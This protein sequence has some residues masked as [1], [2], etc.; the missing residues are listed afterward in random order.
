LKIFYSQNQMKHSL[1]SPNPG[2]HAYD[3]SLESPGRVDSILA[4]LESTTWAEILP[5]LDFGLGPVLEIHTLGYMDYLRDAYKNWSPYSTEEHLAF[6][7]YKPGFDPAAPHPGTIPDQDGFFMTDMHVPVNAF[8]YQAALSSAQCALSA[9]H[10][11]TNNNATTFALCRP[12]GHHAGPDICG[13]YCFLN[14]AAIAANWL[15]KRGKVA[16]LDID[17]HA[18]NGTQAIFYSR[19]DVLTISLHADPVRQYPNYSGYAH[20]IGVG[21]GENFHR[22]FPLP[23]HISDDH[24]LKFLDQAIDLVRSYSPDFLVVSAGL[25]T[26][27]EDPLGDFNISKT[28]FSRIGDKLSSL[29]QPTTLVLEGGY[30]INKLGENLIAL[31]TPFVI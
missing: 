8:T 24:Y 4:A 17:F 26:Y 18:G 2:S 7:P 6:I 23:A 3:A 29:H 5:P 12:P 19:R 10:A 25:D 27:I 16:I 30:K 21:P 15:S 9:V 22:N 31:L 11:L 20:E 14:N 13:G 28:G 1:G